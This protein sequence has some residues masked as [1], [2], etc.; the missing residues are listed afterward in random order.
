MFLNLVWIVCNFKNIL[1]EISRNFVS[2]GLNIWCII[3]DEASQNQKVCKLLQITKE[4][5]I[6]KDKIIFVWYTLH[7][8]ENFKNNLLNKDYFFS[9]KNISLMWWEKFIKLRGKTCKAYSVFDKMN[10][11][12]TESIWPQ[13]GSCNW[14]MYILNPSAASTANFIGKYP[15]GFQIIKLK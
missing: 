1:L 2:T 5:K 11:K 12:L 15:N 14:N 3:C 6:F 4:K 13:Y 7:L 9:T 8:V 10:M